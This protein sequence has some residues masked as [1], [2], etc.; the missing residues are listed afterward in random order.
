MARTRGGE[1]M[2]GSQVKDG[3]V[4]SLFDLT[5]KVALVTGGAIGLGKAFGEALAEYGADVAIGDIDEPTARET[6]AQIEKK[7]RRSLFVKADVTRPDEVQHLVEV[8]VA[9]FGT[10]DILVN[11]AG[12]SSKGMRIHEMPLEVFDRV[13]DIDLRGVFICTHAVLPVMLKQ[14]RGNIINIASVYGLRPFFNICEVKPNA[15]YVTAKTAVIGLTRETAVEYARDGIRANAIVPGWFTGTRLIAQAQGPEFAPFVEQY[16]ETVLRLT[17]MGR[18]AEPNE[19]KALVVYLASEAS[20]FV[21][22]QSFVVDG[23]ISV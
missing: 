2:Q 12:V 8:T 14:E 18:K 20:T 11:N 5:G 9:R 13:I 3:N 19:L 21:T 23:G 16:D 1:S 22:G 7:G 15:A 10:I 4:H 6:A 17:P